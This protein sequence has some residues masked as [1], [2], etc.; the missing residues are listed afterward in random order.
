MNVLFICSKNQRRGQTA[1]ELFKENFITKAVPLSLGMDLLNEL[2]WADTIVVME[3]KQRKTISSWF[4][5]V[6]LQKQ[7]L[8]LDIPD[9]YQKDQPELVELLQERMNLLKS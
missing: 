9:E 1:A 7:V 6:Y 3:R 8:C 5:D 2:E 4:P